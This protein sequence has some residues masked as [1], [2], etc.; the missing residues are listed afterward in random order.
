MAYKVAGG[1]KWWQVRA[2]PG[3]EAEWIVMK[4][5]WKE[6]ERSKRRSK[7][8]KR[9]GNGESSASASGSA[10]PG[11]KG[12]SDEPSKLY[13][14]EN[15]PEGDAGCE[16]EQVERCTDRQSA[17]RWTS[18]DVCCTVSRVPLDIENL[19]DQYQSTAERKTVSSSRAIVGLNWADTIGDQSTPTATLS[20]GTH[21]RCTADVSPSTTGVSCTSRI[22]TT[23]IR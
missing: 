19:A 18:S 23:D 2:G 11:K 5:D 10:T 1:S 13:P 9:T 15:E 8:K 16:S 22:P 3:V 7:G 21:G 20:G 12:A 6:Y 4:K 14:D 17:R